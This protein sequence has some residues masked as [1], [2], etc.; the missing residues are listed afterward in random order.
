MRVH[1]RITEIGFEPGVAVIARLLVPSQQI[2]FL[3][4]KGGFFINEL[5]RATGAG[6]RVFVKE[7]S[8][9]FDSHYH[10]VVQ[11]MCDS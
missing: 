4:G 7:H 8:P 3:V 9:K 10:E 1:H 5:K 2:G 11:V 6:I